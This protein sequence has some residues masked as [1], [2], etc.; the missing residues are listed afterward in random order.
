ME[1]ELEWP[2][3]IVQAAAACYT[4]CQKMDG[5]GITR[6]IADALMA[7]RERCAK[8]ADE[9]SE[10]NVGDGGAVAGSIANAI[11]GERVEVVANPNAE[12]HSIYTP[13]TFSAYALSLLNRGEV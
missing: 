1:D 11:R 7:E 13:E 4:K 2:M 6:A 8:I 3:D 12:K 10:R 5:L 9:E